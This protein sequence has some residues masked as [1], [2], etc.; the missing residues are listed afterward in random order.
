LR[1]ITHARWTC[2]ALVSIIA[3]ANILTSSLTD[4]IFD[5]SI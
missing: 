1:R 4:D 3:S 5:F 2:A